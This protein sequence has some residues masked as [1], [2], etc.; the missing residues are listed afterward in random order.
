MIS[1]ATQ[2][3][4]DLVENYISTLAQYG[5]YDETGVWRVA[6]SPEWVAAQDQVATWCEEAGLAWRR[7]A[8]GNVWGRLEGTEDGPVIATGSHIDSQ[9]P[10]GRFDG[11]LGVVAAIEVAARTDVALAVVAFRDEERSCAGSHACVEAS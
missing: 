11:A 7:D 8:A 4:P 6:F 3:A 5:A 2:V 9:T 1:E 10:G